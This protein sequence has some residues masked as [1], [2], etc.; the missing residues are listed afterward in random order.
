[1]RIIYLA[2]KDL[3]QIFRQKKTALFL[4]ILPVAFTG[5]MGVIFSRNNPEDPRLPVALAAPEDSPFEVYFETLLGYSGTVRPIR[6]ARTESAALEEMIRSQEIAAAVILPEGFNGR[7]GKDESPPLTVLVDRN[8][9]AG[10]AADRAVQLAASRLLGAVEA[11][12]LS[13]DAHGPFASEADRE[14]YA[15]DSLAFAVHAWE[16][17]RGGIALVP[18]GSG[19][20]PLDGFA[21]ASPGMMVLFTAIGM[22]TPGYLLLAERRSRTL[23]RMLTTDL[24][25]AEIIAGH[26]LAMFAMVFLQVLLLTLVGQFAFALDYWRDPAAAV[27]MIGALALWTSAFGLLISALARDEQQVVLLVMSGT[28]L[29]VFLGGAFFPLDLT[30]A[31]YAAIGRTMPSAWAIEGFQDIILRGADWRTVL[32]PAGVLALYALGAY[33]L[34]V[35]RFGREAAK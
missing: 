14:A 27:L 9:P 8:T 22:I 30:G 32:L 21:Q 29:F 28:L 6:P 1:M 5:L 19:T 34:A 16:T 18:S 23:A 3:S 35:W 17:P 10:Q 33:A 7:V 2:M 13:A 4:V 24:R 26:V 25:R 11:A 20:D 15:A 12:R 31:A